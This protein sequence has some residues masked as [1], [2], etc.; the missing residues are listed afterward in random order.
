MNKYVL[1]VACIRDNYFYKKY[2]KF[3]ICDERCVNYKCSKATE[4]M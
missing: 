1:S 4:S 3:S 2:K